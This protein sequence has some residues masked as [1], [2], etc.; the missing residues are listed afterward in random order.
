MDKA[1]W[2]VVQVD[3]GRER[4]A[5]EVIE[6]ACQQQDDLLGAEGPL[7]GEVFSPSYRTRFKRH[8]EWRDEERLLLPGYVVAVTSEPWRLAHVLRGISGYTRILTMGETFAPLAE[9]D[10]SWIERWTTEGDRSIPMSVAYKEGDRVVVTKGPLKGHEGMITRIKRRLCLAELE[11]HAGQMTIRTTVGL[12]VL[13][14]DGEDA[15][16]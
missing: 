11:I 6:R 14:G 12:A 1:Q 3:T 7:L 5:C 16:T 15:D 10:R 2:Y 4:A 9:D 13:P 8:G